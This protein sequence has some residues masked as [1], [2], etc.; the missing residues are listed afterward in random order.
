[1]DD[2]LFASS[3]AP[4]T[5]VHTMHNSYAVVISKKGKIVRKKYEKKLY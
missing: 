2:N 4:S 1:M 5:A 3:Y